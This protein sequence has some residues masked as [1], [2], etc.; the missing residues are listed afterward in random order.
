MDSS[1]SEFNFEDLGEVLDIKEKAVE[2]QSVEPENKRSNLTDG[3][4]DS[5]NDETNSPN[6]AGADNT[7]MS[8]ADSDT[9]KTVTEQ[10]IQCSFCKEDVLKADI[11]MH[12]RMH[13]VAFGQQ[14]LKKGIKGEASAE[15]ED[16]DESYD[17]SEDE[18]KKPIIIPIKANNI[19][20]E[21]DE[22]KSNSVNTANGLKFDFQNLTREQMEGLFLLK[23]SFCKEN[24]PKMFIKEHTEKHVKSP[25]K[26]H[27]CQH[28][29]KS[30]T[31][32]WK[33]NQHVTIHTGE[34]PHKC[35]ICEQSF[36]LKMSLKRHTEIVHT[37]L[38]LYSCDQC[39]ESFNTKRGLQTHLETKHGIEVGFK[40]DQC[41][42]RYL[43]EKGLE[44]HK[45]S[46]NCFKHCCHHCGKMFKIKSKLEAHAQSHLD[47]KVYKASC[48]LCGK[49]FTAKTSLQEH[50]RMHLNLKQFVCE[51]GKAFNRKNGLIAHKKTHLNHF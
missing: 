44:E 49:G 33:L 36:R 35:P 16:S 6:G 10:S 11:F 27:F 3:N 47:E 17:D 15:E 2:K 46:D 43:T 25:M 26:N 39:G 32:K 20:A 29:G 24:V 9:T 34:K 19:K 4:D 14:T 40:C 13:L 21:V 42:N 31:D 41:N 7:N 8:E 30:F 18:P 12:T 51:C 48:H 37:K 28:C 5:S 38:C 45:Q 50:E 22:A 23:C 1:D